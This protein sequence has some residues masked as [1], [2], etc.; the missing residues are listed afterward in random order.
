[1]C[2]DGSEQR[3]TADHGPSNSPTPART[4]SDRRPAATGRCGRRLRARRV[5]PA[6]RRAA[7]LVAHPRRPPRHPPARVC[8]ELLSACAAG[9]GLGSSTVAQGCMRRLGGAICSRQGGW[10]AGAGAPVG[11]GATRGALTGMHVSGASGNA[12]RPARSA[13][14]VTRGATTLRPGTTGHTPTGRKGRGAAWLRGDG[15]RE[16]ARV[17]LAATDRE[18]KAVGALPTDHRRAARTVRHRRIRGRTRTS[19]RT[20]TRTPTAPSPRGPP[21]GVAAAA[22]RSA[23]ASGSSARYCAPRTALPPGSSR[24]RA[25]A[26]SRTAPWTASSWPARCSVPPPPSA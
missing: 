14:S 16:T 10:A 20:R 15:G 26:G 17:S 12:A 4:S 22:S 5:T 19:L 21:P 24:T 25:T 2:R 23:L 6:G 18:A 7:D 3:A 1:M 13:G 11:S 9:P 8:V